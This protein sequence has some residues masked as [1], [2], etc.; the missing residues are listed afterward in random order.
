MPPPG[1]R[2]AAS[3]ASEP[4]DLAADLVA[5]RER[6]ELV[7]ARVL[8]KANGYQ[9]LATFR[10]HI[11][12]DPKSQCVSAEAIVEDFRKYIDQM[13][14]HLPEL[15]NL[16]PKTAV[17]VE[18]TGAVGLILTVIVAEWP[19]STYT[20]V[21][22]CVMPLAS[23]QRSPVDG[24]TVMS[25]ALVTASNDA[26][27]VTDGAPDVVYGPSSLGLRY[28]RPGVTSPSVDSA[29]PRLFWVSAQ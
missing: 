13:Q 11:E 26:L 18:P 29:S 5:E 17:T 10:G 7:A 14:P 2:F 20:G 9:D 1:P 24:V 25:K 16:L 19:A 28:H 8:A 4:K 27:V 23:L 21:K 3:A 6:G 15:F 12:N 22:P